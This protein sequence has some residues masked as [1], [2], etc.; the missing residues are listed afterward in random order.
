MAIQAPRVNLV[1]RTITSTIPVIAAPKPLMAC[2][3]RIRRRSAGSVSVASS[4]FQCRSMPIW[5]SVKEVN[6]PTV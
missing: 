2:E 5:L 4:R 6:T 1:I 3:R